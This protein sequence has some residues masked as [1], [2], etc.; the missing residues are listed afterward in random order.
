MMTMKRMPVLLALVMCL[1]AG[2][3]AIALAG[4]PPHGDVGGDGRADVSAIHYRGPGRVAWYAYDSVDAGGGQTDVVPRKRWES[5]SGWNWNQ[6]TPFVAPVTGSEA[7]DLMV[8]YDYGSAST[9]LWV[10]PG[11]PAGTSA[12]LKFWK[13]PAGDWSAPKSR[14]VMSPSFEGISY[15]WNP[16]ALYDYGNGTSGLWAFRTQAAAF[17]PMLGWKSAAG[18]WSWA[19]SKIAGGD[20]DGDGK[21]DIAIAYDYGNKTTGIWLFHSTG[22][23]FTPKKY[24]MSAAGKWD[25]AKSKVMAGNFDGDASDELMVLYD[26]GN[27]CGHWVFDRSGE[28]FVPT[29]K[30]RSYRQHWL[31]PVVISDV[32]HSGVDD[33]VSFSPAFSDDTGFTWNRVVPAA[34]V[35]VSSQEGMY[36][37]GITEDF[38]WYWGKVAR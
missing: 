26:Y 20:F 10:V 28:A 19:K 2:G 38:E 16:V 5:T 34:T 6:M 17:S 18:K 15:N 33:V 22:T 4:H 37:S 1:V 12:P 9:G 21:G 23:G 13:A 32:D 24:W 29:L 8:V 36:T 30:G 31:W 3:A 7:N 11:G 25:W 14:F 35:G 27:A